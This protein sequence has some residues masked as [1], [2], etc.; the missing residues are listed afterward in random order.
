M[1]KN[2]ANPAMW[3]NFRVAGRCLQYR[4]Q[5]SAGASPPSCYRA[6]HLGSQTLE[7]RCPNNSTATA[8]PGTARPEVSTIKWYDQGAPQRQS[9]SRHLQPGTMHFLE[10]RKIQG[11]L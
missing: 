6:T 4:V 9:Q 5:R 11:S 3:G 10:D 2:S 7:W 8:V 1:A